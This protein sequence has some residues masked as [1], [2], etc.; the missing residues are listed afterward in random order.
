MGVR[1]LRRDEQSGE[2]EA[3]N[4]QVL[5]DDHLSLNAGGRMLDREPVEVLRVT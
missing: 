5:A 3:A 2:A 4:H 1:V